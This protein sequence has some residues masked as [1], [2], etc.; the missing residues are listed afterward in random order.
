MFTEEEKLKEA[1]LKIKQDMFALGDEI[2][3]IQ[4]D[5]SDIKT[6]LSN[7]KDQQKSIENIENQLKILQKQP[8][9]TISTQKPISSTYPA[10]STQTS[11]VPLEVQGLK[12]PNF[13]SSIGNQGAS[14]DRQTD[15]STDKKAQNEHKET[16]Q[17]GQNSQNNQFSHY[18]EKFNQLQASNK[19]QNT[20]TQKQFKTPQISEIKEQPIQKEPSID[21]SITQATQA[22]DSL[23][24]IKKKIRLKFKT[25]TQQEMLVFSAIYQLEEQNVVPID[26]NVV[27]KKLGLSQS[28]IRDYV[29][30]LM[31][32]GIP[33]HKERINNKK[34]SLSISPKL[35]EIASLQTI[36]QL[37]EI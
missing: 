32:K 24:A 26:Y 29:L 21:D 36:L 1:F 8:K 33:I 14:T 23:D 19:L 2:S 11:T 13:N 12:Y 30:R 6:S 37:R 7:L 4:L 27:A 10:T 5:V 3:K 9:S 20:S 34:I 25:I 17:N 15:T 35:K 16:S 28:S 31:N 22:L 18:L